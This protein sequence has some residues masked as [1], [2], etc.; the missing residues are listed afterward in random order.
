MHQIFMMTECSYTLLGLRTLMAQCQEPAEIFQVSKP[1]EVGLCSWSGTGTRILMVDM[2]GPPRQVAHSRVFIWRWVALRSQGLIEAMPCV[3][4]EEV[5]RGTSTQILSSRQP[6]SLLKARVSNVLSHPDNYDYLSNRRW[7]QELSER[8]LA[9]LYRTLS[10]DSVR[11]IA[12]GLS[13]TQQSV[14]ASRSALIEKLGLRNRME[15][16]SLTEADFQ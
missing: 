5:R 2:S 16:L 10:G 9:V 13:V 8:Q 6:L 12:Q 3:L 15:L 11:M 1:E 14:F 4:L 7:G